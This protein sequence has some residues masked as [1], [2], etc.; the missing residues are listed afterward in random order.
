MKFT[1]LKNMLYSKV[2]IVCTWFYNTFNRSPYK[3]HIYF[4]LPGSGKSTKA[5]SIV[6]HNELIGRKTFSN[7]PISGAYEFSPHEDLGVYHIYDVDMIID[8]AGLEYNNRNFKSFTQAETYFFKYHRHYKVN[9]YLFSQSYDDMD[10]KIRALCS[11]LWVV[12]RSLIPK[13][14]LFIPVLRKVGIDELSHQVVDSYYFNPFPFSL[15]TNKRI[16]G[17][18]YY[19][20][21]NTYSHR[22]LP[23]KE[24]KKY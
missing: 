7:V 15:F 3:L 16:F 9:I 8:E 20:R 23:F 24:F 10:K 11:K 21:F 19:N 22:D 5:A 14:V 4:G 2:V 18:F 6:A 12:K 17:P 13:T 1:D